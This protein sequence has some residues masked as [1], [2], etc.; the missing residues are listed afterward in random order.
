MSAVGLFA[1]NE[2][3]VA[4]ANIIGTQ[5]PKVARI[6][7]VIGLALGIVILILVVADAKGLVKSE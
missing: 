6:V 5:N 4:M 3:L 7:C 1:S 2:K